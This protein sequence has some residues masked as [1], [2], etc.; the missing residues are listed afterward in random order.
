LLLIAV[1]TR[2]SLS[3]SPLYIYNRLE[4]I[5]TLSVLLI[6]SLVIIILVMMVMFYLLQLNFCFM[7]SMLTSDGQIHL[8]FVDM[9][10]VCTW[11][12]TKVTFFSVKF[13][14]NVKAALQYT[15]WHIKF[16]IFG[17][18]RWVK[19]FE[20]LK[21]WLNLT[22]IWTNSGSR[23]SSPG[24]GGN[25]SPTAALSSEI[26]YMEQQ[27]L[28]HGSVFV[29]SGTWPTMWIAQNGCDGNSK[30]ISILG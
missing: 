15:Y 8:P 3:L 28:E 7:T 2:D 10:S 18:W 26:Y 24:R 14:I 29:M 9:C 12:I 16:K 1:F 4:R 13:V 23:D 19:I 6:I 20:I 21:F 17:N 5:G 30:Y 22:R 25:P 11:H 27:I